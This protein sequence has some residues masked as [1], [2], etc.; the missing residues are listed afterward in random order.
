M[1]F[2][3][4]WPDLT[5][6][7]MFIESEGIQRDISY[8]SFNNATILDVKLLSALFV[9]PPHVRETLLVV[10]HDDGIDKI[11]IMIP[12]FP[13]RR[14]LR[15]ATSVERNLK[16]KAMRAAS[17]YMSATEKE[18]GFLTSVENVEVEPASAIMHTVT[19]RVY[20]WTL[21]NVAN[22]IVDAP[23]CL[24]VQF[25]LHV[26]SGLNVKWIECSSSDNG[27]DV[28]RICI[29]NTAQIGLSECVLRLNLP[30]ISK[31]TAS[32]EVLDNGQ[33]TTKSFLATSSMEVLQVNE[34]DLV[35][36][37]NGMLR[38]RATMAPGVIWVNNELWQQLR[39]FVQDSATTNSQS[40]NFEMIV[41]FAYDVSNN[42]RTWI[43]CLEI[44]FDSDTELRVSMWDGMHTTAVVALNVECSVLNCEACEF[45]N[46]NTNNIQA[47]QLALQNV[48]T[49]CYNAQ[50]CAIARCVGT[51]VNLRKPLCQLGAVLTEQLHIGR[52]LLQTLWD[53]VT[54]TTISLVELSH[55]RARPHELA[56]PEEGF[57]ATLCQ[58]KDT[59]VHIS[60][61]I[62][63]YLGVASWAVQDVSN[64]VPGMASPDSR[65]HARFEMIMMALTNALSS[66]LMGPLYVFIAVQ[67][68]IGCTANSIQATIQNV[69]TGSRSSGSLSPT[70][71]VYIGSRAIQQRVHDAGIHTCLSDHDLQDIRDASVVVQ[72]T[73]R[74]AQVLSD[75]SSEFARKFVRW[76]FLIFEVVISWLIGIFSGLT[77]L[78]QTSDWKN[79]KLAVIVDAS[80]QA[81]SCVCADQ[82]HSI[83]EPLKSQNV[84]EGALW[85]SGFLWLTGG[86]GSDVLA[87]NPYS[88]NELLTF[89]ESNE[90]SVAKFMLCMGGRVESATAEAA[91]GDS[92]T[93][94]RANKCARYKPQP[95]VFK[96]QGVDIMQIITRCRANYQQKQ[97]DEAAALYSL[98]SRPDLSTMQLYYSAS[99][100]QDDQY[101][102]LRHRM[103]DIALRYA[104]KAKVTLTTQ[105]WLCLYDTI[106]HDLGLAHHACHRHEPGFS[107]RNA[108]QYDVADKGKLTRPDGK[109]EVTDACKVF[110]GVAS[111]NED[112]SSIALTPFLWTGSSQNN[113][114]VAN[115]HAVSMN[116]D[117]RIETAKQELRELLENEIRPAFAEVEQEHLVTELMQHLDVVAVTEEGD[118]LHQFMD[119]LVIG[120][121]A[122]AS[123]TLDGLHALGFELSDANERFNAPEYH[124]GSAT[125]RAFSSN[126]QTGGSPARQQV[127]R[128]AWRIIEDQAEEI[129]AQA[130]G[131]RIEALEAMWLE[132]DEQG[133]P[134]HL[135]CKCADSSSSIE[136]CV[137]NVEQGVWNDITDIVFDADITSEEN[138]WD[139]HVDITGDM[140][141]KLMNANIDE[142]LWTDENFVAHDAIPLTQQDRQSLASAYIFDT[143]KPVLAYAWQD[144]VSSIGNQTLWHQCTSEVGNLFALLPFDSEESQFRSVRRSSANRD[145]F[146]YDPTTDSATTSNSNKTH[147]HA[148][149][150]VVEQVIA[151][152]KTFS[153][154]FWTHVHRYVPS[155]SVWCE[156]N[157]NHPET[158][159]KAKVAS[160]LNV[161]V[162]LRNETL[163]S[164]HVPAYNLQDTVFPANVLDVCICGNEVPCSLP[165]EAC[166]D[167]EILVALPEF[168]TLCLQQSYSTRRELL[169][170]LQA[171]DM[172]TEDSAIARWHAACWTI[173]ANWGLLSSQ[174]YTEW[175]TGKTDTDWALDAQ[176]LATYG[177][178][179]LRIGEMTQKGIGLQERLRQSMSNTKVKS[180]SKTLGVNTEAQHTVGQ[181]ICAN[182]LSDVL[183]DNLRHHFTDVFLPM[184]HSILANIGKSTCERW[185]LETALLT[186]LQEGLAFEVVTSNAI[187]EQTDVVALWQMRCEA[188]ARRAGQCHLRGVYNMFPQSALASPSMCS[189][190]TNDI[191][192]HG[193]TTYYFTPNCLL[194]CD[195]AF[196]DPC[197]CAAGCSSS[198]VTFEKTTCP[199]F[200]DPNTWFLPST[201]SLRWPAP[202]DRQTIREAGSDIINADLML[203]NNLQTFDMHNLNKVFDETAENL[204]TRSD[205][206]G[207]NA[208]DNEYCGDDFDYWPDQQHPVGYHP[209]PTCRLPDMQWRGFD[210]WMSQGHD[211]RVTIDPV[212][213]RNMT[214]ASQ[215]VGFGF[216]ACDAQAWGI[217][218]INLNPY[219]ISTRWD[220][221]ASADPAVP[222]KASVSFLETMSQFGTSS[223]DPTD[224][225]LYLLPG[226]PT[227][228]QHSLGLIR[229]WARWYEPHNSAQSLS[230][231]AQ[232]SLFDTTWPHWP[233]DSMRGRYMA[234]SL[235]P[236]SG[237]QFPP[238]RKCTADSDCDQAWGVQ[239]QCLRNYDTDVADAI[240]GIC[241]VTGS[242]FQHIHCM[243]GQMCDGT[244]TCVTPQFAV[245]NSAPNDVSAQLFAVVGTI[246]NRGVSRFDNIHDFATSN[247]MCSMRNWYHYLN[248]TAHGTRD[249]NLRVVSDFVSSRTDTAEDRLLSERKVLLPQPHP[250]DREF[251]HVS[252]YSMYTPDDP[253]NVLYRE[254]YSQARKTTSTRF[255]DFTDDTDHKVRFCEVGSL[256]SPLNSITGFLN[257]YTDSMAP[258]PSLMRVPSTIRRCVEYQLC[259]TIRF[260]LGI[261]PSK[262][263]S[264]SD[265]YTVSVENRRV[266]TVIRQVD[267][268]RLV[269]IP[270]SR[271]Y[272]LYDSI[273]CFGMGYLI[274]ESCIFAERDMETQCVLD[275]LVAPLIPAVFGPLE[276]EFD[277]TRLYKI[278]VRCPHA[279]A[280]VYDSLKNEELF[281]SMHQLLTKP[282]SYMDLQQRERIAQHVNVLAVLLFG[283]TDI[284]NTRGFNNI[285]RYLEHS[286]CAEYV[287]EMLQE[288]ND[289]Q[290]Q[291]TLLYIDE[292]DATLQ[293]GASL[294]FVI[295][296]VMQWIPLRWILQCVVFADAN[297]GGVNTNW[298]QALKMNTVLQCHNH[299]QSV[300]F[301]D[302]LGAE[303][304]MK[305]RLVESPVLYTRTQNRNPDSMQL[306]QDIDNLVTHAL[307]TLSASAVPD[308]YCI[309]SNDVSLDMH[310]EQRRPI[311]AS[312]LTRSPPKGVSAFQPGA[313]DT[314]NSIYHAV[315]QFLLNGVQYESDDWHSMTVSDLESHNILV[316]RTET[317]EHK[318]LPGTNIFPLLEFVALKNMD[319]N[320][321][322]DPTVHDYLSTETG[323]CESDQRTLSEPEHSLNVPY[324]CAGSQIDIWCSNLR[325]RTFLRAGELKLLI[326]LH[327]KHELTNTLS[328]NS[329]NIHPVWSANTIKHYS[330]SLCNKNFE[331]ELNL[332]MAYE[333][334]AFMDT[335]EY[336]CSATSTEF[337]PH[338]QTNI[339]HGRLRACVDQL[340]QESGWYVPSGSTLTMPVDA[341]VY[342]QGF[343]PTFVFYDEIEDGQNRF[344]YVL[345][346][347]KHWMNNSVT[348]SICFAN[349]MQDPE[350]MNPF[351]AEHFDIETGCDISRSGNGELFIDTFCRLRIGS[352]DERG[353][354]SEHPQYSNILH[355][356]MSDQCLQRDGNVVYRRKTGATRDSEVPLCDA[357]PD[358]VSVCSKIHKGLHNYKGRVPSFEELKYN[359]VQ[360][361]DAQAGLWNS[362][363]FLFTANTQNSL[364]VNN[365]PVPL[366][367]LET[368]I[369]GQSLEFAIDSSGWM[370]LRCVRL[371][372]LISTN[373]QSPCR[374]VTAWLQNAQNDFAW[375][376]KVYETSWNEP[377][378]IQTSWR[379]PLQWLDAYADEAPVTTLK[380]RT[381]SRTR[382]AARFAH[383]TKQ[384]LYAHP[385]VKTFSRLKNLQAPKFISD[386]IMCVMNDS[387]CHSDHL[388][389]TALQQIL[390]AQNDW[391]I[392]QQYPALD[393][394]LECNRILDW[395]HEAYEL[396]DQ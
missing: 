285:D 303:L 91:A 173:D 200:F 104:N 2:V 33:Y 269:Q 347:E 279:F 49:L 375:E 319:A 175:F 377:N 64:Y 395:P 282:Y 40:M 13:A 284:D 168:E 358:D 76:K 15:T 201:Y 209:T 231:E 249:N 230:R 26:F 152:A 235:T 304:T 191:T 255:W 366:K 301:P 341:D 323:V 329:E 54:T 84:N 394:D 254:T 227:S 326:L 186:V 45:A 62:P 150:R 258:E 12:G 149:E 272:C 306:L 53:G 19:V 368:E 256:A 343:Y 203:M 51:V 6:D 354:C 360:S 278:R 195:N 265:P 270:S 128:S 338:R 351:W 334:N 120:P 157:W 251:E 169:V 35:R 342:K 182:K 290:A 378:N 75:L 14:I 80:N 207:L 112:E 275:P 350:I 140:M 83:V 340:Q 184:S 349:S 178:N 143:S 151:E 48:Q 73:D 302:S 331:C 181:P 372:N 153:P 27:R 111:A 136:C 391:H 382:N 171:L 41:L 210:S 121:F 31:K 3:Y 192:V 46:I 47:R 310:F 267:H 305:K 133:L 312:Y 273:R 257:P 106:H 390:S 132:V 202:D 261:F 367:V 271:H 286:T 296:N 141:S 380:A 371:Q 96:E 320:A 392:V 130:A 188:H 69:V 247:G 327:M 58:T 225:P 93:Y 92:S 242:C 218:G 156:Q 87:W 166:S 291:Q 308:L 246:D 204:L 376:H 361:A 190:N 385:T 245:H 61:M 325:G 318:V 215:S 9:Q 163:R 126:K 383:I 79:C 193:C 94:V 283:V 226:T 52:I 179:S 362:A 16:Q 264:V 67:Q 177:L 8:A 68:W 101:Q 174:Q 118:I 244:G 66:I 59:I 335:K 211:A 332:I 243:P 216:V 90:K 222:R 29:H 266:R 236:I 260:N 336:E 359:S 221:T 144:T 330:I 259:P 10:T 108:F 131:K 297:E 194:Y 114:A 70:M 214:R 268:V 253:T 217:P 387:L 355:N 262:G 389:D 224:T 97:W 23:V 65:V 232:Q 165:E 219:A 137:D 205:D 154:F 381:P 119:C 239:L 146:A 176:E 288:Q 374:D 102:D 82:P 213:L 50:Q 363:N 39:L 24:S 116:R 167:F 315:R 337:K 145:S 77:D 147:K 293:V 109:F 107:D 142:L 364:D 20:G 95:S 138:T 252:G 100:Q 89:T 17:T 206:E 159:L 321:L 187:L 197:Q 280:N 240:T 105:T 220:P 158:I 309:S 300:Y 4:E 42:V 110:S 123:L 345:T 28:Q 60:A 388:L 316:R 21:A 263:V 57:Q 357:Q 63:S 36:D 228:L 18:A 113:A 5:H 43:H 172:A 229:D 185:V 25:N 183:L 346:S 198:T 56:W 134:T 164:E 344:L 78:A 22:Q 241:A 356:L 328:L 199:L 196:Y 86:D 369:G 44:N 148:L 365:M 103:A 314:D 99:L 74:F 313:F 248:N 88:L 276:S 298:L 7:V 311:T 161:P 370:S 30:I 98:F 373:E 281:A 333:Y 124:R 71:Q 396:R 115:M 37:R 139:V 339:M 317:L 189:W 237:C 295:Q 208:L 307:A 294:Y 322:F 127:M 160:T 122:S 170:V 379:C 277:V 162:D 384:N 1:S 386:G 34:L 38:V 233:S 11:W 287:S 180:S 212:R 32:L 117:M 223:V 353:H 85:C 125:S 135:M 234:A 129:V 72:A 250:C 292:Q 299:K 352:A 238:L 155:E 324:R 55:V 274:G 81:S 348:D 393:K 289:M